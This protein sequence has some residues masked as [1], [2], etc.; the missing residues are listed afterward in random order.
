MKEVPGSYLSFK[1]F[2]HTDD[3]HDDDYHDAMEVD[4]NKDDAALLAQEMEIN[5]ENGDTAL[6]AQEFEVVSI[7]SEIFD[8]FDAFLG[9]K[10]ACFSRGE[11][12]GGTPI[13]DLTGCAVQQGVL[14]R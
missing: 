7:P 10:F 6:S 12:G 8:E 1:L 11:E 13:L 2:F 5:E 9:K 14:L 4:E 3:D